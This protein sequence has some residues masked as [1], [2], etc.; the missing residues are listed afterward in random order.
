MYLIKANRSFSNSN[1]QY[2][3]GVSDDEDIAHF[4]GEYH[5]K[6][7][8]GGHKYIYSIENIAWVEGHCFIVSWE[9]NDESLRYRVFWDKDSS[10]IPDGSHKNYRFKARVWESIDD[11]PEDELMEASDHWHFFNGKELLG[12]SKLYEK[13]RLRKVEK[14]RE[15][16]ETNS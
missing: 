8:R 14:W 15:E 3:I 1:H 9:N 7:H 13:H 12:L 11:I 2:I 16:N 4:V 5:C 6:F 10:K